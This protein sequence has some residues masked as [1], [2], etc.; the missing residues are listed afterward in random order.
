MVQEFVG[1]FPETRYTGVPSFMVDRTKCD[2]FSRLLSHFDTGI[3]SLVETDVDVEKFWE[4]V[5][6]MFGSISRRTLFVI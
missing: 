3:D 6:R 1:N 5:P 2:A 4:Q